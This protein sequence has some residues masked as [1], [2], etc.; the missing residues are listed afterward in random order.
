MNVVWVINLGHSS[1]DLWAPRVGQDFDRVAK[2]L[3]KMKKMMLVKHLIPYIVPVILQ[4]DYNVE[5]NEK[6]DTF[7]LLF[8]TVSK[9][10]WN[11][12]CIK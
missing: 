12:G 2:V 11:W 6:M 10:F 9:L 8:S 7:F 5:N 1:A 4:F 3:K